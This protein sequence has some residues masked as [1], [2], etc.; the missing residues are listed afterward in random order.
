[1]SE[2]HPVE[3]PNHRLIRRVGQGSYGEVWLARNQI[4]GYRAVKLIYRQLFANARPFER[5]FEGIQ[6]FEPLSR[7]HPGF[8][9]ILHVGMNPGAD[10]FFYIMEL[11]DDVSSGQ[12]IHADSY[13]PKTLADENGNPR[14]LPLTEVISLGASLARALHFL[15][16]HSLIHRD[17][18]P[19]NIVYVDGAPKLA[20]LGLVAE[21]GSNLSYVG[22]SGY[23]PP[24]GAI[25]PRS[26]IY[27]LGK[28]L[29][30]LA[31]GQDRKAF[32]ELPLSL[33]QN[34]ELFLDLNEILIRACQSS[35]DHRYATAEEMAADLDLLI[36]GKSVRR[37]HQLERRL[38]NL[39]RGSA[40]A[41]AITVLG[42]I[43]YSQFQAA[44]QRTVEARRQKMGSRIAH[45]DTLVEQ[46][47]FL[48]AL[49]AYLEA[50]Q[51]DDPTPQNQSVHQHRFAAALAHAPVLT[52]LERCGL[53]EINTIAA[54]TGC[55]FY[56]SSSSNNIFQCSIGQRP[57]ALW[58]Q[59]DPTFRKAWF[60]EDGRHAIT[61]HEASPRS[62]Q[63]KVWELTPMRARWVFERTERPSS[64]WFDTKQNLL[65]VGGSNGVLD[66][67]DTRSGA[68]L[69]QEAMH[70]EEINHISVSPDGRTIA[71]ASFDNTAQLLEMGTWR[72]TTRALAHDSW[73]YRAVFHPFK[74]LLA[75]SSYDRTC[76]IWN[77]LTGE[78]IG[79]PLDSDN[80]IQDLCFSPDGEL[81]AGAGLS[82]K[83]HLWETQTFHPIAHNSVIPLHSRPESLAFV[84]HG[85]GVAVG[86]TDGSVYCWD[87]TLPN[88]PKPL[89]IASFPAREGSTVD[90]KSVSKVQQDPPLNTLTRA[91]VDAFDRLNQ[92]LGIPTHRRAKAG[93]WIGGCASQT[94]LWTD[95]RRHDAPVHQVRL[96]GE[97]EHIR[98]SP[99][100]SQFAAVVNG[101]DLRPGELLL[102]SVDKPDKAPLRLKQ[103][104]GILCFAFSPDGQRVATGGEDF[105]THL[106]H[107]FT[108]AHLA[109]PLEH[110]DKVYALA[111]SKDGRMLATSAERSLPRLWDTLDGMPI[112]PDVPA[113]RITAQSLEFD[114]DALKL[115]L[116]TSSGEHLLVALAVE[117]RSMKDLGRLTKLLSGDFDSPRSPEH[118]VEIYEKLKSADAA[119]FVVGDQ[120]QA[121]WHR[122]EA[123]RL[124]IRNNVPGAEIHKRAALELEHKP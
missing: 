73:V 114:P 75:T 97:P 122:E 7:L 94:L 12:Q 67:I 106:W 15:H 95:S 89:P 61:V 21:I 11:A 117:S 107:R 77:T 4:G 42:V 80:G 92:S 26:D 32:P 103:R 120:Q 74:P 55:G 90:T 34:N 115:Q 39:K 52:L 109:G 116:K 118:P 78:Q 47:R 121:A 16:R 108:G 44:H 45:G 87:L 84:Q 124:A 64:A 71:T 23:I 86:C 105:E 29:Y 72:K 27:S 76:R 50:W 111:F 18:K 14:T 41:A 35:A 6:K 91:E 9:D 100:A 101:A 13:R 83:V 46:G 54:D 17:I 33:T 22:T 43:V 113:S 82:W 99:D 68:V 38:T 112:T 102:F 79:P 58:S 119:P 25:H 20:D 31:T 110:R 5:E 63:L 66:A 8:L 81:L 93:P 19:S 69:H 40:L 36:A 104:D 48:A 37:Y 57:R 98:F 49:P 10:C 2:P 70:K 53:T 123:V 24:E 85:A 28:V 1:M 60:P 56:A 51:L 59:S 62:W 3:V 30:E 65:L 96:P 88:A